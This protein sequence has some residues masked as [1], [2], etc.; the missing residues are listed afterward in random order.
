MSAPTVADVKALLVGLLPPGIDRLISLADG[1]GGT[2][3]YLGAIAEALKAYGTDLVDDVRANVNPATVTG[4]IPD[5][6]GALGL[7]GSNTAQFGTDAERRAAIVSRLREW[8]ASTL[9]NVRAAVAPL[10]QY[11]DPSQ[12][13]IIECQRDELTTEHTYPL[14]P[15]T[16]AASTSTDFPVVVPDQGL[17]SKGGVRIQVNITAP[18]LADIGI[19]LVDPSGTV[20]QVA[21]VGTL[22]SGMTT[23]QQFDFWI[24]KSGVDIGGTWK[25]RIQNDN[26]ATGTVNAVE[27][28]LFLEGIGRPVEFS[29]PQGLGAAI[30]TFAVVFDPAKSSIPAPDWQACATALRRVTPAHCVGYI[31]RTMDGGGTCAIWEDSQAIWEQT[32]FC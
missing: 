10:F 12:I 28:S 18:E 29:E 23:S 20:T 14:T 2:G 26:A 31:A 13:Q 9:Q 25:V 19:S 6:E 8:G 4:K 3:D 32:I 16:I 7:D 11:S 21:A 22:G 24:D 1:D 5:W 15:G 27:S 30:F 17:V